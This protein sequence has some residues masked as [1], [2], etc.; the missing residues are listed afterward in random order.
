MGTLYHTWGCHCHPFRGA[1]SPRWQR[2]PLSCGEASG[3]VTA[4]NPRQLDR[5]PLTALR[6]QGF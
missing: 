2:G 6:A 1:P 5:K 3:L 4:W